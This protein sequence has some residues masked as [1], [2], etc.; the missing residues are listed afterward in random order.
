MLDGLAHGLRLS[1]SGSQLAYTV[2]HLFPVAR[3]SVNVQRQLTFGDF[4]RQLT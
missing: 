4:Q 3:H 1:M 2:S